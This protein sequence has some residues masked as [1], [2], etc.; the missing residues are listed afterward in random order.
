MT[1]TEVIHGK[2][3]KKGNIELSRTIG[4]TFFN[5]RLNNIGSLKA[6]RKDWSFYY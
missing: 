6:K 5:Q 3:N 2:I 4:A 1:L